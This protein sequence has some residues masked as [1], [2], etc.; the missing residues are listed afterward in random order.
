MPIHLFDT[1]IPPQFPRS[2]KK[3]RIIVFDLKKEKREKKR[4][5]EN[6]ERNTRLFRAEDEPA[7]FPPILIS[8]I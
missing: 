1:S 2:N 5:K 4:K 6:E 7:N 3:Y 8:R